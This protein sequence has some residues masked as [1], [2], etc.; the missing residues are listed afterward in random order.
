[1]PGCPNSRIRLIEGRITLLT[2]YRVCVSISQKSSRVDPIRRSGS[3]PIGDPQNRTGTTPRLVV[4]KP[5]DISTP[6]I[7]PG[8]FPTES[9]LA[10]ACV[11]PTTMENG[12]EEEQDA[13]FPH[14][15]LDLLSLGCLST[16]LEVRSW[17]GLALL[18][19]QQV[20]P[21]FHR[22]QH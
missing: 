11:P 10:I 6:Y 19:M 20:R 3:N 1:M 12:A 5:G 16:C 13:A 7:F 22:Y 17:D 4:G 9:P 15:D 18:Q 8:S 2:C 14:L 21:G